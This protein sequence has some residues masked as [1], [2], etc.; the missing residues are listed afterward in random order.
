[1][2]AKCF[3]MCARGRSIRLGIGDDGLASMRVLLLHI[4]HE[5]MHP[6]QV[7]AASAGMHAALRAPFLLPSRLQ[8]HPWVYFYHGDASWVLPKYLTNGSLYFFWRP[9][10][11]HRGAGI[12]KRWVEIVVIYKVVPLNWIQGSGWRE[13]FPRN[14]ITL[15]KVLRS[16]HAELFRP[17]FLVTRHKGQRNSIIHYLF[18]TNNLTN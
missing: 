1:M 16:A 5:E 7:P 2:N 18:P 8:L 15:R 14:S 6:T 13:E 10:S 11:V 3:R 17:Q 4:R 9:P 12:G